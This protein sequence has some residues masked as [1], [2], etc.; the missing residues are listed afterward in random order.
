MSNGKQE[1][2]SDIVAEMRRDCPA[3]HMDGT[4]YRDGDF[5]Y[6][7]GT[8][9]KLADRIEEAAKRG[10]DLWRAAF[11][12]VT[13]VVSRQHAKRNLG[14]PGSRAVDEIM[15]ACRFA[16]GALDEYKRA[17]AENARL[18]AALKPVLACKVLSAMTAVTG[19]GES[20]YC[21]NIIFKAQRIYNEGGESEVE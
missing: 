19:S 1:T 17:F 15:S 9:E 11:A 6:T 13:S 20:D 18:R 7:N 2:I 5:V 10:D 8:V 12:K 16:D 21:S 14:K 4:R 3:R